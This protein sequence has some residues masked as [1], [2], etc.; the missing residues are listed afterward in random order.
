MLPRK[1]LGLL[2]LLVV[3]SVVTGLLNP[4]FLSAVNLLD[5]ANLTGI[6]QALSFIGL[7][8]VLLGIGWFYQRLLFRR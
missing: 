4:Q 5:M 8:I 7:G 3:I 6:Y 2:L 1:E